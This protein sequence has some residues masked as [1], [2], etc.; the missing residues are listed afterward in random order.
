MYTSIV[1][2]LAR[3]N[4]CKSRTCKSC[5]T[6]QPCVVKWPPVLVIG[7]IGHRHFVETI[8]IEEHQSTSRRGNAKTK[9]C[10]GR[11]VGYPMEFLTRFYALVH[12][13]MTS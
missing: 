3:T 10:M 7:R 13:S 6:L 1:L 9:L 8:P 2:V 4:S 11:C 12:A 5:E